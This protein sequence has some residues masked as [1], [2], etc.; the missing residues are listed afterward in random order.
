[1]RESRENRH[2]IFENLETHVSSLF[3]RIPERKGGKEPHP[4]GENASDIGEFHEIPGKGEFHGV[5][6]RSP[7]TRSSIDEELSTINQRT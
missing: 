7:G 3:S 4:R 6:E 2:Y 5:H 1:M